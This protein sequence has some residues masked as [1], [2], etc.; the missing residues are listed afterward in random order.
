M[1][2]N[3]KEENVVGITSVG[4]YVPVYRLARNEIARI[5]KTMD[6]GGERSVAKHDED[7]L[8]M[9][10][11]A[12]LDCIQFSP[13]TPK[14]VFFAS[15]TPP[16]R[17]K[18][19]AA[20]LSA[21][22]DMASETFTSDFADSVRA[23][24]IAMAQA[25]DAVTSGSA[26]QVIVA[27]AD[28]RMAAGKSEYEQI[29]GDGAVAV[30]IGNQDVIACIDDHVSLYN[31]FTDA[32]RRE[33]STFTRSWENRFV[34]GQG[35]IRTMQQA[36]TR[37]MKNQHFSSNDFSKVIFNGP[38]RKSH[39]ILAKNLGF[40]LEGQIQD[41]LIDSIGNTGT[42]AVFLMLA[43]AL[44]EARSGDLMLLANYGDGA[45]AF[46]LRV[47]D[48]IKIFHDKLKKR[49]AVQK[50]IQIDYETYLSWRNLL[51][52]ED[53]RHPE[54]DRTSITCSWR[55]QKS[56]LPFYGS[57]CSSCGSIQYPP[58][59]VCTRCQSK[60]MFE[61]YKFSD[62]TGHVFTYAV[63][64][65]SWGKDR[66]LLVGVVDFVGGGRVMCEISD[67]NPDEL[68][69]GMPVEMCFRKLG[70]SNDVETYFWKAR[71]VGWRSHGNDKR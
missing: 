37:I 61:D 64:Q 59:R 31:A 14:G 39:G 23:G 13:V 15:T 28:C 1:G 6:M 4:T 35:Y 51:Q 42:A 38:N 66:P 50:R 20:I 29:L 71:P 69:I 56:I 27:A 12:T 34:T 3:E 21:A 43:A 62:K 7:S 47:T 63:D 68:N 49:K 44:E 58:Q 60:D 22:L 16:Y 30:S 65:L 10:V 18:Q 46:V 17:E 32:W 45:D 2:L 57:K 5:W 70:Q 53:P 40:S 25:A 8:T 9:A 24:T 52:Y 55:E 54:N 26:D 36:I 11:D 67:C 48:T 19:T 41:P 33:D